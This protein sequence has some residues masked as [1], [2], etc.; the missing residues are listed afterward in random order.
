M[1]T[2]IIA[3]LTIRE[4]QRR[5]M[6]WVALLLGIGFLLLFGTAFHYIILDV[7]SSQVDQEQR[8]LVIGLLTTA[9]LYATNVLLSLIAVL[10]S[11]ATLSG[12]ID[13][14]TIDAIITKPIR[15]WEVVLGKWVG[16]AALLIGYT[17][18]LAGGIITVVYA[19]S[20]F[21]VQNVLYG[22]A[23]IM[24]QALIVLTVTMVG[25]TR[26]ST[27]A[28][29]TVA[30]MLYGV[31]FLGGWVEQI[32]ALLR[33][34]T[35]VDIGIAS[36]LI[37]PTEILSKKALTLFLPHFSSSSFFA[38]PFTITSQPNGMMISY[39]IGYLIAGIAIALFSFTHRDF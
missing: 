19:L 31:A 15:R 20:G 16:F 10:I 5:R 3:Q 27:L 32:G 17:L 7:D 28:N 1:T 29:G 8:E 18:L 34:E 23:L 35:A 30:F 37:M 38:G 6:L 4:A 12:E 22:L 13:S 39:A 24:L 33:N 36:S 26:L 11:A 21:S 25:G 14:H 2:F 9:G